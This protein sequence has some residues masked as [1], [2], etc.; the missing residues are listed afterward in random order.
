MAK[1]PGVR[2]VVNGDFAES[3]GLFPDGLT[4]TQKLI[5]HGAAHNEYR[6]LTALLFYISESTKIPLSTLKLNARKL[7]N[8][9]LIAR[10]CRWLS[11]END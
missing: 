9:G 8:L 6:S 10:T 4:N 1:G 7:C 11:S 3:N 2:T 5:L